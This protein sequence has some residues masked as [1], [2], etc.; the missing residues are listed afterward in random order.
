MVLSTVRN[1]K[2]SV[3]FVRNYF[4]QNT[5]LFETTLSEIHFCSKTILCCCIFTSFASDFNYL[6]WFT[7]VLN[8]YVQKTT[9]KYIANA[10]KSDNSNKCH[11]EVST[12]SNK[13]SVDIKMMT[14]WNC[15]T[16]IECLDDFFVSSTKTTKQNKNKT[17]EFVRK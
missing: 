1:I 13:M 17:K 9:S 15:P 10:L 8:K 14:V 16:Q 6:L 3:N 5:F 11:F 2:G 7:N 12:F 4:L